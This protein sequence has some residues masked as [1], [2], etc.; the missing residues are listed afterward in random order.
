L[1]SAL[2]FVLVATTAH[3]RPIHGSFGA[4]GTFLTTGE[5]GDRFRIDVAF[6][7]K[8]HSRF[9]GIV[10]WRAL[11][12]DRKGLLTAGLV[13]E[14]GAARPRLVLDLIAEVGADLDQRAPLVGGGIRT[15]LT[16][17]GPLGVALHS[18]VYFIW[19]GIDDSR[20]Q[21]QSNALIVARW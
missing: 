18:G 11:D 15:T 19:D 8:W 6:D 3:A 21:L 2:L 1:R 12:Q 4:G 10:A 14:G 13:Y 16:I 7:L 5:Q 9:G 17:I 20:L